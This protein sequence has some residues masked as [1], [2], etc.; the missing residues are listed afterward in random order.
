MMPSVNTIDPAH[1]DVDNQK[2]Q[3]DQKTDE[4]KKGRSA[5]DSKPAKPS[6]RGIPSWQEAVDVLISAN[7]EAR[8]KKTNGGSSS[9][10]RGGRGRGSR[11]KSPEKKAN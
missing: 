10:S 1:T 9:H 2:D 3:T 5:K 6:H 7:L 11:E 4:T 8:S